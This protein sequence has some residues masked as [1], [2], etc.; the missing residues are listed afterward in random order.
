MCG[1]NH[2]WC[3]PKSIISKASN[4]LYR[5][6]ETL[7][8]EPRNGL[9]TNPEPVVPRMLVCLSCSG[10]HV[11]GHFLWAAGSSGLSLPLL[12]PKLPLPCLIKHPRSSLVAE[13]LWLEKHS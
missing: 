7:E 10:G 5:V 1:R 3:G 9:S 11:L 4:N 6:R 8:I 13:C 2:V 12:E